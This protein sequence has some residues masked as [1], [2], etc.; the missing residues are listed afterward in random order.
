MLDL[1]GAGSKGD[2]LV[3]DLF[4]NRTSQL[5]NEIAKK[6]EIISFIPEQLSISSILCKFK[7]RKEV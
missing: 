1:M 4:K 2:C 6:D 5:E 3:F 7:I